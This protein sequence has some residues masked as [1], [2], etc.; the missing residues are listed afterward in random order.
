MAF[1]SEKGESEYL[2]IYFCYIFIVTVSAN[3]TLAMAAQAAI[4]RQ[5]IVASPSATSQQPGQLP[6]AGQPIRV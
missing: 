4:K 1:E 5:P 2:F 3:G 6:A